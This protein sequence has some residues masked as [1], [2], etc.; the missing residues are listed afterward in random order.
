ML[1]EGYYDIMGALV[2]N[3][4]DTL[5]KNITSSS[6]LRPGPEKMPVLRTGPVFGTDIYFRTSKN[7]SIIIPVF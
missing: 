2:T 6:D 1:G 5:G 3:T 7:R 4:N